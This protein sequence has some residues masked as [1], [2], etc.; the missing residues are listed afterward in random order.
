MEMKDKLCFRDMCTI[1]V[2]GRYEDQHGRY[3][4]VQTRW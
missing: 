2:R 3:K 1:E 4:Y